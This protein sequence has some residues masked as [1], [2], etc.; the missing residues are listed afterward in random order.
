MDAMTKAH[1]EKTGRKIGKIV[2]VEV[3]EEVF[4]SVI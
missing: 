1:R 3:V 4:R 2:G